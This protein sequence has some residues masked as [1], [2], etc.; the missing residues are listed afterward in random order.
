[1]VFLDVR[2]W[3]AQYG[4]KRAVSFMT[5]IVY[6]T[7]SGLGEIIYFLQSPFS[8]QNMAVYHPLSNVLQS[9][10]RAQ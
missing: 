1:M 3:I 7:E 10:I 8:S 4:P 5:W 2:W 9:R 6:K